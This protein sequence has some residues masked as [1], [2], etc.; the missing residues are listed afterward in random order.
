MDTMTEELPAG[1]R[2]NFR[3]DIRSSMEVDV[4]ASRTGEALMPF[5]VEYAEVTDLTTVEYAEIRRPKT[6]LELAAAELAG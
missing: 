2:L 3:G 4:I 6:A 5:Q 1:G